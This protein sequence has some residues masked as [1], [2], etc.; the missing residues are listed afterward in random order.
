MSQKNTNLFDDFQ[1]LSTSDWTEKI[2]KDLKGAD[3]E[4]KLVKETLDGIKIKPFYREEDIK[5]LPYIDI[6]PGQFP[7]IRG[8]EA[9]TKPAEVHADI[10]VKEIHEA[11]QKAAEFVS[12]GVTSLG[13]IFSEDKTVSESDIKQ[14][15]ADMDTETIQIS[16]G[17]HIDYVAFVKSLHAAL[18]NPKNT[19][20]SLNLDPLGNKMLWGTCC[21]DEPC[22]CC[23]ELKSVLNFCKENL[24]KY[25][26][27][28]VNAKHLRNAG[29]TAVQE[30]GFGMALANDYLAR[31]QNSDFKPEDI[32]SALMFNFGI[33]S[34]YFMEIAKLRAARLLWSK[35]VT[36]Y[37]PEKTEAAKTYFHSETIVWNKTVYDAYVNMLRTTTESM[38]ALLG[39]TDSLSVMPFDI[40]YKKADAFSER[41]A[42]NT[43]IILGEEAKFDRVKDPAAGAYFIEYLTHELAENAWELF[44]QTEA[45]G[46]FTKAFESGF[47]QEEI[48][49]TAD[50]RDRQIALGKEAVLGTNQFPNSEE[51]AADKIDESMYKHW[52]NRAEG[53]A[54]PL[55]MYR[56]SEA[57]EQMR[58]KTEK[59]DKSPLVFLLTIGN[60]AMRTARATFA[61]NFFGCAGF[62]IQNNLG[63]DSVEEGAEAAMKADADI[64]VLCSS[65]P[66]YDEY[67]PRAVDILKNKCILSVAGFPKDNVEE[68]K[69]LGV[70]HFIHI[71]SDILNTLRDFQKDLGL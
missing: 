13:F 30:L 66:E 24:P 25:K 7:Y 57:F 18:P 15:I 71:K 16:F 64:V 69:R 65:D 26:V 21:K 28:S 32:T 43:Q 31:L 70:K 33:G 56:G 14:L 38:S 47:I 62:N 6:E 4:K 63:F 17:G 9:Q 61:S 2:K 37:I 3:F 20:G 50:A 34:D 27:I 39:G 41:I 8:N 44:K 68:F 35:I 23:K 51:Q 46:G 40:T 55:K 11:A 22:G 19:R 60:P 59:A 12:K 1:P 67:V 45:K 29:A 52:H 48:K 58:L 5:D 42:R 36:A 10:C 53:P 54:E 49:R